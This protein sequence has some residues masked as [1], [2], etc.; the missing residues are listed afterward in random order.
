MRNRTPESVGAFNKR[1]GRNLSSGVYTSAKI[2]LKTD[3]IVACKLRFCLGKSDKALIT[4]L[5]TPHAIGS[6]IFVNT[7]KISRLV[8]PLSN[9]PVLAITGIGRKGSIYNVA[10]IQ[11]LNITIDV[12]LKVITLLVGNT[13][14]N[15]LYAKVID[16]GRMNERIPV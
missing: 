16:I 10:S 13:S 6:H 14:I 9:S 4:V 15:N 3:Y 1:L 2:I 11:R 5:S 7:F 12:S 8:R